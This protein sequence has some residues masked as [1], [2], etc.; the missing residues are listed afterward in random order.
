MALREF[1]AR[2]GSAFRTDLRPCL[3]ATNPST[4]RFQSSQAVADPTA[5]LE[6]DAFYSASQ[7]DSEL[8][9][10]WNPA[11]RVITGRRRQLP[12][13][14]YKFRPPKYFRGRLHPIQ[15]PPASDPA[16]R[17]FI[18]GPFSLTRLEQTYE[19]TIA[20]DFMALAYQHVPPGFEKPARGPRLRPWE[21]E[22]PYLKNRPLKGPRGGS[23]LRL[24]RKPIN[25]RYI[26]KLEKISVHAMVPEAQSESAYLHV[27]GMVMQAIT[28]K[29]P[30]TRKARKSVMQW[31]LRKGRWVSLAVD[32]TGED[33]YHFLSKTLDL[34]LPKIRDF[35]GFS[36]TT[37]DG[38]GNISFGFGPNVT[39]MFPEVE[40]NYDMYP[41]KMIPGL[42]IHLNTTARTDREGKILAGALGV[43]LVKLPEKK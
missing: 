41:A 32:L 13:S 6:H 31:G 38:S 20:P 29:K 22:S 24:L 25:F 27:G 3:R 1:G 26:P 28:G 33:M 37:G 15:P 35:P 19:S 17:E 14:R 2:L 21:G 9:S 23:A 12:A 7:Q 30:D 40:I 18:P 4:R 11:D 8:L 34:V 10:R 43:P 42:H 36:N 16:S 39:A 5:D